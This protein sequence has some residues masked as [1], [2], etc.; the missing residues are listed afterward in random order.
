MTAFH[1]DEFID[2]LV[3]VTPETVEQLTGNGQRCAFALFVGSAANRDICTVLIGE[4]CPAFEGV[5]D[6]CSISAGGSMCAS[7]H[8]AL[9][10]LVDDISQPARE[11][12]T[13]ATPTSP[14][15]GLEGCITPRRGK[16]AASATSTISS[17]PSWSC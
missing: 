9:G 2:F 3:N 10:D 12:S 8:R 4:D 11:G 16:R 7:I 13:R 17:S 14:S 1:T 15:I 5:F 6:F